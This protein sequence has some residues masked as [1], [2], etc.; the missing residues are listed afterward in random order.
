MRRQFDLLVWADEDRLGETP[1]PTVTSETEK[2]T[3]TPA[4]ASA[5]QNPAEA[6]WA[7][8]LI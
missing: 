7:N 6:G 4:G 2:A 3:W 8:L 5:Q 1:E